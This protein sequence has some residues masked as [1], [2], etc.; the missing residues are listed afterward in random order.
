MDAARRHALM[1]R[2]NDDGR[3]AVHFA[4]FNEIVGV[5]RLRLVAQES[6]R[7]EKNI[8][9]TEA[10][11]SKLGVVFVTLLAVVFDQRPLFLGLTA[12]ADELVVVNPLRRSDAVCKAV[13]IVVEGS[14]TGQSLDD[15][16]IADEIQGC[17]LEPPAICRRFL[18]EAYHFCGPGFIYRLGRFRRRFRLGLRGCGC[19]GRLDRDVLGKI[20][21]PVADPVIVCFNLD[22]DLVEFAIIGIVPGPIIKKVIAFRSLRRRFH[23]SRDIGRDVSDAAR[24]GGDL[25]EG[26]KNVLGMFFH[27]RIIDRLLVR[28]VQADIAGRLGQKEKMDIH[29]SIGKGRLDGFLVDDHVAIKMCH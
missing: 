26:F 22:R 4:F 28:P 10:H 14:P 13:R 18:E 29:R 5:S 19:G 24:N 2:L 21:G 17:I 27:F 11:C 3:F 16:F 8:A 15:V 20:S 12:A 9:M 6:D 1:R 25:A 23:K 7:P